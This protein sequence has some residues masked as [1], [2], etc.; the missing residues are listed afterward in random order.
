MSNG[1]FVVES[2]DPIGN[3]I[4]LWDEQSWTAPGKQANEKATAWYWVPDAS[5]FS[6]GD[7]A[8]IIIRKYTPPEQETSND[9]PE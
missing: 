6:K 8:D 4:E 9:N 2:V 7:R 3:I 1:T 5:E